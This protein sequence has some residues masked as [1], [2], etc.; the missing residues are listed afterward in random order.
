MWQRK[1]KTKYHSYSRT[2][3]SMHTSLT[4]WLNGWKLK[5]ANCVRYFIAAIVIATVA[6]SFFSLLFCLCYFSSPC[7]LNFCHCDFSVKIPRECMHIASNRPSFVCLV[8]VNMTW[9][10]N[11]TRNSLPTPHTIEVIRLM[12]QLNKIIATFSI[13]LS[14]AWI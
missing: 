10:Q 2:I 13:M 7:L 11:N 9:W 8:T 3:E 1:M 6:A 5:S 14:S 12:H 4:Q